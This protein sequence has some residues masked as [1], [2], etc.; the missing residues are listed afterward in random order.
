MWLRLSLTLALLG[1]VVPAARALPAAAQ[2]IAALRAMDTTRNDAVN[3]AEWQEAS[4]VL[5]RAADKN[6]DN[7]IDAVELKTSTFA[8]D[9]FSR[10]DAD[11]DGRLSIDEFMALRREI[12]TIADYNRDDYVT[13]V[14]FELLM[15]YEAVG[16]QEANE[17]GRLPVAQLR[18]VL[19]K[20]F[21][22]LDADK[23]GQLAKD[24]AAYMQPHHFQRFDQNKDGTLSQEE[25]I[26]GYRRE[27]E[28]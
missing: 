15:V 23:N 9:T 18:I 17:P 3:R 1:S 26:M 12:F 19:T 14:E 27:F 10:L 24:E 8:Q 7:F 25:L 5:F 16:W 13:L 11:R 22:L 6:D 28:A 2:V 21:A 20:L 4:F